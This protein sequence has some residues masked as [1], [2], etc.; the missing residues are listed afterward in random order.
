LQLETRKR[1][2]TKEAKSVARHRLSHKPT[3]QQK[4]EEWI[5]KDFGLIEGLQGLGGRSST[6]A[7]RAPPG[8]LVSLSPYF[9]TNRRQKFTTR[10]KS[11]KNLDRE[12]TIAGGRR[13]EDAGDAHLI[14]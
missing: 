1:V 2:Q 3:G 10:E 9:R 5:I 8:P 11:G 13:S 12:N 4:E 7:G 14:W 6:G